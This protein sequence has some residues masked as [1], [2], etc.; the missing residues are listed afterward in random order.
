M[1]ACIG[2]LGASKNYAVFTPSMSKGGD[3]ETLAQLLREGKLLPVVKKVW[4]MYDVIDAHELLCVGV[5]VCV[6]VCVYIYLHEY[7]YIIY[8]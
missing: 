4:S 1:Y 6:C 5:C 7:I 3:L 8:I 2:M